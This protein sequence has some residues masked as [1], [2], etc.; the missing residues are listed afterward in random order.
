MAREL[1]LS[2]AHTKIKYREAEAHTS[3]SSIEY[4]VSSEEIVEAGDWRHDMRHTLVKLFELIVPST[5]HR[6][7]MACCPVDWHDD[8]HREDSE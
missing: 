3:I 5:L 1:G 2:E 4:E 7:C 8:E 6:P